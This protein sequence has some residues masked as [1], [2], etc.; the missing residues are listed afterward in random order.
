MTHP[1]LLHAFLSSSLL[2]WHFFH[3]HWSFNGPWSV[4]LSMSSRSHALCRHSAAWTR[5]LCLILSL[6]ER[7]TLS[8]CFLPWHP[9]RSQTTLKPRLLRGLP[10]RSPERPVTLCFLLKALPEQISFSPLCAPQRVT[11][12]IFSLTKQPG[13]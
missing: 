9:R 6:V 13:A 4:Y 7:S 11:G 2:C 12:R 10:V 3:I 1:A 8:V 5:E